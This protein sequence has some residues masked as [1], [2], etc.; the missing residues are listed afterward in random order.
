[1]TP[2]RCPS[3]HRHAMCI[4]WRFSLGSQWTGRLVVGG[5]CLVGVAVVAL[6]AVWD[7]DK[8]LNP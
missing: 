8:G 7:S 2:H 6:D 3:N 5:W 1:M 4:L